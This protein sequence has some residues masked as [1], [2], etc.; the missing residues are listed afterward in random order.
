MYIIANLLAEWLITSTT[1]PLDDTE[2]KFIP[3]FLDHLNK[4]A[5]AGEMYSQPETAFDM[6]KA[7]VDYCVGA[8]DRIPKGEPKRSVR[9]VYSQSINDIV[10]FPWVSPSFQYPRTMD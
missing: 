3:A 2:L 5:A 1:D 8:Y 7:F 10:R 4:R 6:G 9:Q